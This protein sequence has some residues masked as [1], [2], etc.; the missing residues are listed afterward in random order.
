[1]EN[2]GDFTESY[3]N[4]V[5][6]EPD[7]SPWVQYMTTV[8][9]FCQVL[10]PWPGTSSRKTKSKTK[11]TEMNPSRYCRW[12]D[13]FV[14]PFFKKIVVFCADQHS[15]LNAHVPT[16]ASPS[17]FPLSTSECQLLYRPQVSI[18]FPHMCIPGSSLATMNFWSSYELCSNLHRSEPF[19][20]HRQ[21]KIT[22]R[23]LSSNF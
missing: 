2:L 18:W 10:F 17:H 13:G 23:F 16:W 5:I 19:S 1:M 14:F 11:Q 8:Y 3:I 21:F 12:S 7:S 9:I 6:L 20:K 22:C 15:N 4:F